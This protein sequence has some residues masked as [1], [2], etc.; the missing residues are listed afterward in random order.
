[1]THQTN[2]KFKHNGKWVT[3]DE[4]AE[5]RESER[6]EHEMPHINLDFLPSIEE[7]EENEVIEYFFICETLIPI[8]VEG[9]GVGKRKCGRKFCSEEFDTCCPYCYGEELK[10]IPR[11]FLKLVGTNRDVKHYVTDE[12]QVRKGLKPK[13]VLLAKQII[14]KYGQKKGTSNVRKTV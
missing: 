2:F 6:T 12:M 9:V 3:A 8:V 1:M 4:L 14:E 7:L 5:L 13:Y 11:A 10:N